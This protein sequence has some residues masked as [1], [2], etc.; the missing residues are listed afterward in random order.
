MISIFLK[1]T[2]GETA[3]ESKM[4]IDDTVETKGLIL[5][6]YWPSHENR[7]P[8]LVI[9]KL[10]SSFV[11]GEELEKLKVLTKNSPVFSPET[12]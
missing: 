10:C 1:K 6:K 4:I 7:I 5:V 9:A 3:F 11:S 12:R 8:K 2:D